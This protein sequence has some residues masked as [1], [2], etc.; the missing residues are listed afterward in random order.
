M[1]EL[2]IS[3][4]YYWNYR[5]NKGVLRKKILNDYLKKCLKYSTLWVFNFFILNELDSQ[6]KKLK[7]FQATFKRT[8]QELS[9]ININSSSLTS[10]DTEEGSEKEVQVEAVINCENE[11]SNNM[12]RMAGTSVVNTV[13]MVYRE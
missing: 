9:E 3:L 11:K 10:S 12:H 4:I 6:E 13:R 5:L 1:E 2:R 8:A 7:K